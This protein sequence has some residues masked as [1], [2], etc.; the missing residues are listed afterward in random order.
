MLIAC[1]AQAGSGDGKTPQSQ[2]GENKLSEAGL[3]EIS[4]TVRSGSTAHIFTVEL[5]KTPQEQAR[6]LMFRTDLK[7]DRGMIFPFDRER[8]ASFWMKNT[9][10]PLDIIFIRSDG[11]IESIAANTTPYSLEPVQ[12]GEP[13]TAVLE[14]AGGRADELGISAGD[15][16]DWQQ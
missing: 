13:V 11:T 3:K 15:K 1:H 12:S 16:V 7:P 4:L 2:T 14:I 5:A 10:I 6:G 8:M 9:V